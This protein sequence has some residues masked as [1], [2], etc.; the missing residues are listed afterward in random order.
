M[1]DDRASAVADCSTPCCCTH[2]SYVVP[3]RAASGLLDDAGTEIA[4]APSATFGCPRLR[5]HDVEVRFDPLCA[6]TPRG[7]LGLGFRGTQL[8]VLLLH[9]Q[10]KPVTRETVCSLL[11]REGEPA[12]RAKAD[13]LAATLRDKLRRNSATR[14]VTARGMGWFLCVQGVKPEP[15]ASTVAERAAATL[16]TPRPAPVSQIRQG[17]QKTAAA[18]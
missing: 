7:P 5:F 1:P 16:P 3:G 13:R 14:L 8:L 4:A 11:W 17:S 18:R 2:R 10:G 9:A 6:R 15:Q 12:A